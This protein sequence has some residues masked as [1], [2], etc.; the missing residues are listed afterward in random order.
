MLPLRKVFARLWNLLP[1]PFEEMSVGIYDHPPL[2]SRNVPLNKICDLS[3]WHDRE[4]RQAFEDL[5]YSFDPKRVHRKEWEFTQGL[6]GLRRLQRLSPGASALGLGCG[7]EPLIYFLA[8]RLRKVVATDLYEGDFSEGEANP[9]VLSNPD[10]YAPFAYP[11]D[12]LDVKRMNAMD[13]DS[14]DDSFDIVFS[15]SSIEHF[16]S[17]KA[18]GRSLAEIKRVLR[19]GGIAVIT[20]EMILNKYGRHGD[21][22]QR[23]ELL[24]DLIPGSGLR[25]VGDSFDFTMSRATFDGLVH[26]PEE[27]YKRPHLI[28]KRWRTYY[29]SCSLIMEKPVKSGTPGE[30][31]A[32][33]G[34][35]IK[36]ELSPLY[37]A[38]IEIVDAPARTEVIERFKIA[39]TVRNEGAVTWQVSSKDGIGLVR[40]GAHLLDERGNLLERDFGRADLPRDIN[41]GEEVEIVITLEAPERGTR[42]QVELDM[43]LEGIRWFSASLDSEDPSR[44]IH[45]L[46]VL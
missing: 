7:H 24:E 42:C 28:L 33:K 10:Y 11:R 5:G 41:P 46:E 1:L 34:E 32:Q 6:Y 16:G 31:L 3:D 4:W 29:T 35:E 18:Q 23:E 9:Q 27:K 43:V 12:H 21:Y 15:F 40:L 25:L 20:T 39:C 38:R 36:C 19:P 14:P 37:R 17:R 26:L 8:T 22:F 45:Q 30:K 44:A 13:I 2:E